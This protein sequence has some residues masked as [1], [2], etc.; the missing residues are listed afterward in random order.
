MG[1]LTKEKF[2]KLAKF[3]KTEAYEEGEE[4][5][6]LGWSKRDNPYQRG[7]KSYVEWLKGWNDCDLRSRRDENKRGY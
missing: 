6:S 1:C 2:G 5:R 4:A 3:R 7:T